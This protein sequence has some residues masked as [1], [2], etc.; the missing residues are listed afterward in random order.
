MAANPIVKRADDIGGAFTLLGAA[1]AVG[2]VIVAVLAGIAAHGADSGTSGQNL[3]AFF[4]Q[5]GLAGAV[6]VGL[7]GLVAGALIAWLGYVL[8]TL[9]A[10]H[11]RL[12]ESG[13]TSYVDPRHA[14]QVPETPVPSFGA[15]ASL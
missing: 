14:S 7:G 9:V 11:N 8:R 4:V 10:I 12:P 15:K 13:L 1:I 6:L 5:L 3:P 2:C